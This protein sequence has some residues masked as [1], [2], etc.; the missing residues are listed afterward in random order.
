[1][2][3]VATNL[4]AEEIRHFEDLAR[5]FADRSISPIFEGELS[6]GDPSRLGEVIDTSFDI[7]IPRMSDR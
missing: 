5:Q 2:T 1:M 3:E 6:D 7:G 4:S